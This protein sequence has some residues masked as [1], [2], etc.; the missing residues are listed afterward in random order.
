M[1]DQ[2]LAPLQLEIGQAGARWGR[3]SG[4]LHRV[5][6]RWLYS[7]ICRSVDVELLY[8]ASCGWTNTKLTLTPYLGA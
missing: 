5:E 8:N 3:V 1:I 4:E 2:A 6:R 7:C